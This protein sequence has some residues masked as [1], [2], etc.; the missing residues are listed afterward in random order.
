M[1]AFLYRFAGS[2]AYS[3]PAVPTF[4]DVP[5]SHVFFK[6]VEWLNSTGVTTGYS[7]GTFRPSA[8]VTRS[9][10][11]AFLYRFAGSPAYSAP[12]VP[13]FTDVPKSHAFFKEVEWLNSTGVTTG[14]SDG[15]FGPATSVT[16]GSMAGFLHRFDALP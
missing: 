13:T 9:S 6:E 3:A 8:G 4:T 14:Y 10:M 15:T 5:K 1:A 11:A 7:D 12:A 16:R 2:P